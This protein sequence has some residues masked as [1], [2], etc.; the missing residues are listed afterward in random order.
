MYKIEYSKDIE[1]DL[2][3]LPKNEI[4]KILAKIDKLAKNPRPSGIEPLQGKFK[5][6]HR[7]RSAN[8]RIVYQIIDDRLIVL[9]VRVSHRRE[10]YR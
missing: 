7:I 3:K 10:V 9:V 8:Y 6:L 1:K 2:L 4:S 5:G